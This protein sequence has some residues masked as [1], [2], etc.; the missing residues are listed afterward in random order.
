MYNIQLHRM[1]PFFLTE[2]RV[3][4]K[5]QADFIHSDCDVKTNFNY[6]DTSTGDGCVLSDEQFI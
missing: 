2:I 6:I 4:L 3:T 5:P 1:A